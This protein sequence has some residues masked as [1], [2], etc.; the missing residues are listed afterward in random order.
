MTHDHWGIVSGVAALALGVFTT[1]QLVPP[2]EP[3][4]EQ[5]VATESSALVPT[6]PFCEGLSRSGRCK[7]SQNGTTAVAPDVPGVPDSIDRVL[8]Q[9]GDA[10][11]AVGEE[12]AQLPPTVTAV[13]VEYGV[14]LRVASPEDPGQ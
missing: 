11:F 12:L 1:L 10:R 3:A 13:L 7:P 14:T 4:P 8:Q 9:S 6:P 2:E 5:P